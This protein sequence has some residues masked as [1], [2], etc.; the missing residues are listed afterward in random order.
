MLMKL[1]PGHLT[2]AE[3]NKIEGNDKLYKCRQLC[4][5]VSEYSHSV[6][7]NNYGFTAKI[8]NIFSITLFSLDTHINKN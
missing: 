4:Q 8:Y 2:Q 7:Q 5:F 6:I 1:T 3:I